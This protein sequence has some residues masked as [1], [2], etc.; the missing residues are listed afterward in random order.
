MTTLTIYHISLVAH[1]VGLTMM[2]GTTLVDYV[3]FKQF[4][5]QLA[6]NEAKGLAINEVL[7]KLPI[8]FGLGI[9]LLIISGVSMMAI[10]HG[11]FGE[12][13]WFR[14]KFGLV[15][16]IIINGLAVG[17]RLGLK[18]RKILSED[19]FDKNIVAKLSKVKSSLSLFHIFQMAM[20]ITIFVLSVFKFN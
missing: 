7:S 6:I 19:A 8:L 12:Q 3:L 11:V 9:M 2:A 20:F 14:I 17:R 5:K 1:I 18:L 13:I 10:T 16:I 15:I 4:W